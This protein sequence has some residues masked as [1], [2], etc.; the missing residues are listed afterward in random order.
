MLPLGRSNMGGR[1][2]AGV[3]RVVVGGGCGGH[4]GA[5]GGRLGAGGEPQRPGCSDCRARQQSRFHD[6]RGGDRWAQLRTWRRCLFQGR[7]RNCRRLLPWYR[8]IIG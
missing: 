2:A 7:W 5:G 8:W 6:W 4:V 1:V 3:G